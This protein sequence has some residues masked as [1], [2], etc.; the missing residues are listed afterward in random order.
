MN[1]LLNWF[2]IYYFILSV[3]ILPFLGLDDISLGLSLAY[4]LTSSLAFRFDV[5]ITFSSS[6]DDSDESEL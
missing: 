2:V 6:D 5:L 1:A 4:F 3:S